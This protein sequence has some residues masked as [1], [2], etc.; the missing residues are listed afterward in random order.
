MPFISSNQDIIK[1]SPNVEGSWKCFIL[2]RD[3][4]IRK[5]PVAEDNE[6]YAIL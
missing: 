2:K 5:K 6:K 4:S 1:M 3:L